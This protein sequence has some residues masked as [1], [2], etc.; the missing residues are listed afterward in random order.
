[1]REEEITFTR[2]DLSIVFRWL[3]GHSPWKKGADILCYRLGSASNYCK[4]LAALDIL[5]E[6]GLISRRNEEGVEVIQVLPSG[7][8]AELSDSPTYR[9]FQQELVN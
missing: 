3:R 2:D 9:L 5:R 1:M 6:L 4:V 7:G 8:K